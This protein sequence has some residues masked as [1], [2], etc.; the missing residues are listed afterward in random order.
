MHENEIP[1]TCEQEGSYDEVV[2]C[3][4]CKAELSRVEKTVP[5]TGHVWGDWT[6]VKEPTA[7]ASG[8]EQR[9]CE[10]CGAK[11]TRE[12]AFGGHVCSSEHFK[13]VDLD[14]WYHE[15][16]DYVVENGLM[17]GISDDEFG[18]NLQ[19]TRAMVVTALY[20]LEGEP[21]PKS[22]D[23]PFGDVASGSWYDAAVSWAAENGIVKGMS[24]EEFKPNESI[25]REQMATIFHRYA[26]Y[27]G[28]DVSANDALEKFADAG[29]VSG[30]ALEAMQW[31]VGAGLINGMSGTELSPRGTATR[32]QY[33]AIL[34][35]FCVNVRR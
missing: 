6:T 9:F 27:K 23:R 24:A 14:L 21:A 16:L 33:A 4:V 11:Q 5:A 8:V 18:P 35:R 3:T 1:A 31:C 29:E 20:R 32:I 15:D 26:K 25:T 19:M 13:D 17:I 30:W 34:H 10:I 12:K 28:F 22:K 7:A 2:Y